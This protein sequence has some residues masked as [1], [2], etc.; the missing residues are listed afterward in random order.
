MNLQASFSPRRGTDINIGNCLEESAN[1]FI[2][3]LQQI[4]NLPGWRS[5][6]EIKELGGDKTMMQKIKLTGV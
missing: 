3:F 1:R 4:R 2:K 6:Q 5:V